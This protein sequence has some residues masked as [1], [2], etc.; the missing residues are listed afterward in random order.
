MPSLAKCPPETA[1]IT[2]M[3]VGSKP[4][5]VVKVIGSAARARPMM[6]GN[7]AAAAAVPAMKWRRVVMRAP[8]CGDLYLFRGKS[9]QAERA[10]RIGRRPKLACIGLEPIHPD[11][12]DE[13]AAMRAEAELR[14]IDARRH[15]AAFRQ[16]TRGA[17]QAL[18]R[19]G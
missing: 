15:S 14:I 19:A 4:N 6:A 17:Q 9:G 18:A 2:S 1:F 8:P 10:G 5:G 11:R 7:P 16:G 13:I 3:K 12:R